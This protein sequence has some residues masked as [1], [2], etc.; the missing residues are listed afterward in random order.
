MNGKTFFDAR[1][2]FERIC[3]ENKLAVAEGF[4]FATCPGVEN[5]EGVVDRIRKYANFFVFD[6]TAEGQNFRGTNGGYFRRRVFSVSLLRRYKVNDIADREAQL[7]VCRELYKQIASRLI[8]DRLEMPDLI[9][10]KT[11]SIFYREFDK[12]MLSGCTGLYFMIECSE[13]ENLCY[14]AEQWQMK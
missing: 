11:D 12:A 10:L 14:N 8:K 5:L 3:S 1:A 13:P 7:D 6:D 2:Y 9:Y 4:Y